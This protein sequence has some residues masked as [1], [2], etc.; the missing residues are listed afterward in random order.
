M[1]KALVTVS[2]LA[3]RKVASISISLN[4]GAYIELIIV[5]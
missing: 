1:V 2:Y 5:S 3:N 4:S